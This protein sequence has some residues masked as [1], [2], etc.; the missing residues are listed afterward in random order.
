MG[1]MKRA[2]IR[3]FG[4]I[5]SVIGLGASY[6]TVV[7]IAFECKQ[8]SAMTVP[9]VSGSC[10]NSYGEVFSY[11]VV[12]TV[13][14]T[15]GIV[16]CSTD[17]TLDSGSGVALLCAVL[18]NYDFSDGF[19][20]IEQTEYSG[21]FSGKEFFIGA[22]KIYPLTPGCRNLSNQDYELVYSTAVNLNPYC[23]FG[24]SANDEIASGDEGAGTGTTGTGTGTSWQ[25]QI[26]GWGGCFW[27]NDF[28][29]SASSEI[30][31]R[32]GCAYTT[33]YGTSDFVGSSEI[34]DTS[35]HSC[36][37]TYVE[38]LPTTHPAYLLPPV[39]SMQFSGCGEHTYGDSAY[40]TGTGVFYTIPL[41][42]VMGA[43]ACVEAEDSVND[44]CGR[45]ADISA[46]NIFGLFGSGDGAIAKTTG[47][48]VCPV[49]DS[50]NS[51]YT[52]L[53]SWTASTT[54][55]D[56]A[57][58]A[59]ACYLYVNGVGSDEAGMYESEGWCFPE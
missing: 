24:A 44:L 17:A 37:W 38:N 53:T 25:E 26:L 39:L 49:M 45:E 14:L 47:C 31:E 12:G 41:V 56:G 51:S 16:R 27:K 23:L 55:P 50:T 22:G 3:L 13:P 2:V 52:N 29:Y 58:G 32:I 54:N 15:V 33:G 1:T 46:Q 7:N 40:A 59:G 8:G 11:D 48:A 19:S 18:R 4:R 43:A 42:G 28:L 30:W 10:E 36:E 21:E 35:S 6:D 20:D 5:L 57:T 9:D 34:V